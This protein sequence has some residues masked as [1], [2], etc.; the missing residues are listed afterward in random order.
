MYIKLP[1]FSLFSHLP[2]LVNYGDMYAFMLFRGTKTGQVKRCYTGWN[3][4]KSKLW[5]ITDF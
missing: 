5:F 3:V 1:H 2:C 4:V